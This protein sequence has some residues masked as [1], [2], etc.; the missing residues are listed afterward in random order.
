M[1]VVISDLHFAEA[2]STQIGDL[3]FN[4][5]LSP[6]T[7]QSYFS[8]INQIA[9]ANQ[10]DK[11]D[12]VLAGDI[13]ELSRSGLWLASDERPYLRNEDVEPGSNL[14]LILLDIIEAIANEE[15]VHDTLDLFNHIQ[16]QFEV[17]IDVHYLLGNHD[18]LVNATPAL[19]KNV[20]SLFG[21]PGEDQ[22]FN[23]QFILR[24][25]NGQPFCLVRHGH[26][27]DPV[28]FRV[29]THEL[30]TF[31][32][33]F[34]TDAYGDTC[35]GDII[36]LEFGSA[37]AYHFVKQYGETT[38]LGDTTLLT[39]YQRLMAFDDVRPTTALLPFLFSTPRL[40]KK[41]TWELMKPCFK[42]VIES[43]SDNSL[44][45]KFISNSSN[46]NKSQQLL[47]NGLLDSDLLM[48]DI[49]YWMIKQ[50]MKQVSKSIK[51]KSPVK[52]VKHEKLIRDTH[53]GCKCVISG[54]THFPEVSLISAL[55]GDQRY[56]LNTGTWRNMIPATKNYQ[57][58]GRLEAMAK[59]I[60]FPPVKNQNNK[61]EVPW[62]FHFLSGVSFGNS[63]N[64]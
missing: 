53:S 46:L 58:F 9:V 8:E 54:H 38:V 55:E 20:R 21:L 63:R 14:E 15:R 31:P 48:Q 13:L 41:K 23:Y 62:S 60:V 49:P 36:T 47:L 34:P 40:K 57:D 3:R 26:E 52:W 4:R 45:E 35:L 7:Y 25:I 44:I 22:S 1:L 2:Q 59:V 43:L 61:A 50:T 19:R 12:L 27:Y 64:F 51:L 30:D 24:D 17:A 11:I 18:R 16:D 32:G 33:E 6:D 29:N 10:I 42:R 39:L 5:N 56:Y 37:L 28:N